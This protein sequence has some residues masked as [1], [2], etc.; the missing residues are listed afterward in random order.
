VRRATYD[1]AEARAR[2]HLLEGFA[3]ALDN[4]DAVIAI[5]RAAED[6]AAARAQLMARFELSEL[7]TNAILEMRLRSLTQLE[8]GRVMA[9]L[10]EVRAKIGP[11]RLLA[12]DARVLDETAP[13]SRRSARS[14][15]TSGAPRS[16]R[17]WA[18]SAPRT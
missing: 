9:E 8:R 4:L 15:A 1:L 5:I 18:A 14:T 16:A 10:E 3:V 6:T 12:S 17:R 7:Q 2:A 13:S 11:R